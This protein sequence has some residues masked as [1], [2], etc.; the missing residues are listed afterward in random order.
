MKL[1]ISDT[2]LR[3]ALAFWLEH[4]KGIRIDTAGVKQHYAA[5]GGGD[6]VFD[7]FTV[8][9]T[10]VRATAARERSDGQ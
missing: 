1:L 2:E 6:D 4:T 3:E 8:E 5:D 10:N 7:G 9:W